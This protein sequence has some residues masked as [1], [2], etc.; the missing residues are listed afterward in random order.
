ML[1]TLLFIGIGGAAGSIFRWFISQWTVSLLGS[2]FP[3]G[4]FIVN[5]I[6]CLLIGLIIQVTDRSGIS[7]EW[8]LLLA[9][10]FCG[11]FTTFSAYA[12][13]NLRMLESGNYQGFL[14]YALGSVAAG[15]VGIF[16]GI[17]IA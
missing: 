7:A 16:A 1:R 5:F 11:G 2:G 10:G 6:G 8:R 15:V 4:T 3:W 12:L 13:E 14:I 17:K 9:T